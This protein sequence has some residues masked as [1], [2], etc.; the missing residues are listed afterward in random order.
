MKNYTST[1]I[2]VLAFVL[3]ATVLS[4]QT[5]Y[6]TVGIIGSS[7]PQ[8]WNASTAM[9]LS[10]A[11]DPHQWTLTLMLTVGEAKFR[12]NDNWSVNWGAG[13]F[14]SGN[15]VQNGPN[16]PIGASGYYTVSFNDVTGAYN[17]QLNNAPVYTTVGL[18]GNATASGWDASTPMIMDPADPHRWT[19][20]ITLLNGE[21]KFRAN[22]NW[23]VNWGNSAFP[24]GTAFQNGAN[25]PVAAGEYEV[26]FNDFTREY[27]FRNLNPSI[28]ETVGIIGSATS[29]GWDASTPM[30]QGSSVNDWTLTTYLTSG[31][32]KF[33]AN[34]SWDVNWG[35]SNFPSGSAIGNGP[36][37]QIPES[38]WY[39]IQFN[40]LANTYN[41]IKL[42]PATY[43][44]V[45]IIGTAASNG[46]DTSTPMI[47]QPDGHTWKLTN[48]QLFNGEAKFR[49]DNAW[50]VN[51]GATG[52]PAGTGTQDGPN[53]PVT[54]GFYDITFNDVTREYFFNLTGTVVNA[55]VTLDP[56]MPTADEPIT[57]IYD[58]A[59]GVSG[60][61]GSEKV[62]M[63]AGVIL[64][65][66]DG[67]G[68]N[69]VIGNWGQD[70]GVGEMTRVP[71]EL[72]KWQITI[73]SIR[74]YFGVDAGVPV[75]RLGMVFRSAN[76]ALTGKSATDGDI[77]VNIDAGDFTRF[78]APMSSEAFALSGD[79]LTIS[80]EASSMASMTLEINEGDGFTVVAQAT[81]ATTISYN[82]PVSHSATLQLRVT[83]VL[84]ER[85]V[86]SLKNLNVILRQPNTVA[87]LPPGLKN[88][89]NYDLSDATKATLVLVAPG[90][91]FVYA[92]GDFN[93]WNVSE[94]SQ[95]NQT[96]DGE[97][98]WI[99]LDNLVPQQEYVFQYWVEGT[100]RIGDP[101]A[102][103]VADPYNDKNI[104]AEV[105]PNPVVYTNT[106]NGIATVLQTAQPT[107]QWTHPTVAGGQPAKENLV[108]YE[109]L[110]RDFLKSHSYA[111]LTD[112]LSYLKRLGVNAIE[113]LPIMEFEGNESWGYNPSYLFAPD[114]YY[115]TKNDL[116]AFI[117]TAH[118][119]GFVVLLDMV[120]NHQFGQSPMVRMY[121]DQTTGKPTPA[122]PWFNQDP[123]HPF[124]VGYDFNHESAYTK[125][126]I[127]DVNRYWLQE[128]NFDGYRFDLSKGFTQVN[129]PN[130]VGAWSA[131]D[132]SRINILKRMTD[133]IWQTDPD[134]YIIM[135]HLADNSEEKVLADYGIMLW[136]NMNFAYNSALNGQ[137]NT[138]LN[139]GLSG[140]RN[141]NQKNL[142]PYMESHDEERLMVRALSEGQASG[143]YNIRDENTALERVKLASAFFYPLPGP[144]MLWQFGELGYDFSINYNG[145]IG[146]KP[147]PWGDQDGLN[148]HQDPE[149]VK[150]YKATAAIINL[151]NDHT[152]VFEGGNFS[153]T[154][155]GQFRRI[156]VS[157]AGMNVTIIGNFGVT[158]GSMAGE[159]QHSGTW[160]D[161]FSGRPYNFSSTSQNI[162]LQPGEF[163]IFVDQ[164]VSFPERGLVYTPV[165]IAAPTNLTAE[166]SDNF[167][168]L[169]WNDNSD[170]EKGYVLER[171]AEDETSFL[172][173]ATLGLDVISYTDNNVVDG[174]SYSY[175][176]KTLS[177]VKPASDWSNIASAH[178][179]LKAP[180]D[181]AAESL[182]NKTIVVS[183][184]D[185]SL[186][187]TA[188]VVERSVTN[189]NQATPFAFVAEVAA[190]SQM[191]AD[192][193]LPSGKYYSYRVSARDNDEISAADE[194]ATVRPADKNKT[195]LVNMYPNAASD[196]VTFS[197]SGQSLLHV[198]ILNMQGVVLDEFDL[199]GDKSMQ[200]DVSHWPEGIYFVDARSANESA[201]AQLVVKH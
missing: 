125:R 21:A 153:W 199:N 183:W 114:K 91:Q 188:Y 134:A 160:Y 15:G 148:Y 83:A 159:F 147:I 43:T 14:P 178:L 96:P 26:T 28:Y 141:W 88:G 123:T 127:D 38:A 124:N 86:T 135:E 164:L 156:S 126:Y 79:Q 182:S 113:L 20:T 36:N 23:D 162:E 171:M 173:I 13:N 55:I 99:A 82:Y 39:T 172:T 90:K 34:N 98:F 152:E 151:V 60:L 84:A 185:N 4:A 46:W 67:A 41:F 168:S 19:L 70:D 145:R 62:Y 174:V 85:T 109:L 116:K 65:G 71:G 104:P 190:G 179:L 131:Y 17:F 136:G 144:K 112:T 161:Y 157:H 5:I 177:D 80:A 24:G 176:V 201:R 64:S 155:T 18:I 94:T 81:N 53:I 1:L 47:V 180:G 122:S 108:I 92:V 12:A 63:H 68:W 78:T 77:F 35:G 25:I 200:I 16:I 191:F 143:E 129:N 8:G 107:F 138:D 197:Q 6:Q 128:F 40:D 3:S 9:E 42:T 186:H 105:Y 165:Y 163:H 31:E 37:I 52:F 30:K 118:E 97:F 89:I 198:R 195:S 181:V 149:R 189:G 101:Y 117:N 10:D 22:N 59:Q 61:R 132:Q 102:D 111:D 49:A 150:L 166:P 51:W 139:W 192:A 69:N 154:P 119:Q 167:V 45:G 93:N 72:N 196:A 130:D 58:A 44:T 120:L 75:F 29:Q 2:L 146:N 175:R 142:V 140:T 11:S 103:K 33:R 54:G 66:F 7:T 170:G 57:I 187:E 194:I 32:L 74:E 50:T 169:S 193:T 133:V 27:F 158:P 100:I 73:P 137:T 56:A 48:A 115:G 110:L 95:M 106:E 76:G 87:A 184:T 121:F